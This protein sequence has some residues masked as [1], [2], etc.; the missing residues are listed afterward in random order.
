[1]LHTAPASP[2]PR[3][4]PSL[5]SFAP[6]CFVTDGTREEYSVLNPFGRGGP[7][8]FGTDLAAATKHAL[9][10]GREV[11]THVVPVLRRV[12]WTVAS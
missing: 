2:G 4:H 1:M 3:P 9:R 7:E 5:I 8:K 10:C 11:E 12:R 6:E